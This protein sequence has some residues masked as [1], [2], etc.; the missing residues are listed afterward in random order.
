MQHC[1]KEPTGD[2]G[3]GNSQ[4]FHVFT[5]QFANKEECDVGSRKELISL[6]CLLTSYS[7]LVTLRVWLEEQQQ[8][9]IKSC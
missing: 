7:L 8:R 6:F 2:E 3:D 5:V 4:D 9:M 1:D